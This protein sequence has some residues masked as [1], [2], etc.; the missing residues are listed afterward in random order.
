[1]TTDSFDQYLVDVP[2]RRRT[3][4]RPRFRFR[5]MVKRFV[6]VVGATTLLVVLAPLMLLVAVMVR[7]TSPGPVI[8]RQER[9]GLHRQ[10]FTVLKFRS[11]CHNADPDVHRRFLFEHAD[12]GNGDVDH[13][14]VVDDVRV[15]PIGVLIR[16]L[17]IDEL[18]QL[19]NVLRGEMSLVG[20]RPDIDYSLDIYAPHHFRRFD[21]L[22]GMTGLWQVSGRSELS[23]LEML[24]LDVVYADTWSLGLDLMILFRTVPAVMSID[25]AG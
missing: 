16:K 3:A 7:L 12:G 6:D 17:S 10:P 5:L 24:D 11:M 1:M 20:P 22:P 2:R 25:R 15:T 21:V 4:G 13:F 19:V 18:P 14:K 9:L 23:F 8:F